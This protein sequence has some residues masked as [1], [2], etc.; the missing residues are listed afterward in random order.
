MSSPSER[1]AALFAA[2]LNCAQSLLGAF[3]PGLGLEQATALRLASPF[4][5]GLARQ[6]EVCGAVSG[7]LLV[8]GLAR[9][10]DRPEGKEQTYQLAQ[11]FLA[12][13]QEHHGSLI[14]RTLVGYDL[15]EPL[16][17][18]RARQAGVFES[19]CPLLVC[20]AA[21]LVENLLAAPA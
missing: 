9:G 12:R 2:K 19:R 6:G 1:A 10:S 8:L 20:D 3:A 4:G 14:C 21:Q 16:E 7:A 17:L 15:R 18:E 13:F 5:A 11:E